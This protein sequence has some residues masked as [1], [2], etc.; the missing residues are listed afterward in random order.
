MS[1][2]KIAGMMRVEKCLEEHTYDGR[3]QVRL[4]LSSTQH[5]SHNHDISKQESRRI[6]GKLALNDASGR[7]TAKESVM[8][9]ITNDWAQG[10]L[11][12]WGM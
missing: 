7:S 9:M 4:P 2:R 10:L 8:C 12:S 5:S 6:Q 3:L 1:K 11:M